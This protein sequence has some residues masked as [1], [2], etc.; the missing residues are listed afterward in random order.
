MYGM[1]EPDTVQQL[2]TVAGF[3]L[4]FLHLAGF[5]LASRFPWDGLGNPQ[6]PRETERER[7]VSGTARWSRLCQR[8][9]IQLSAANWQKW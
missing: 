2:L 8:L 5:S 1:T 9:T 3:V 4:Y 7:A 6:P